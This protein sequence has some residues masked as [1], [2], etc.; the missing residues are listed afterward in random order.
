M[1]RQFSF[2]AF[3]RVVSCS[4]LALACTRADEDK[5]N[6]PIIPD[7]SETAR[8][9]VPED[10]K[11]RISDIFPDQ[12]AW[13]E[14]K[15][16]VVKLINSI[17]DLSQHW[18][19]SPQTMA[20][21]LDLLASINVRSNRLYIY[22]RLQNDMDLSNPAFTSMQGEIRNM[23]VEL[24]SKSTFVGPDVLKLGNENIEAYLSKEPRLAKHRF[25]LT[26]ILRRKDHILPEAQAG[27]VAN[28]GLFTDTAAKTAGLFRDA[29]MPRAEVA[30][31]DGSK[32]LLNESNFLK[33][34]LS[35]KSEDRRTVVEGYFN[36][37]RKFQSTYAS[38]LDGEM[39]KQV[40]MARIHRF[41]GTLA[42]SLFEDDIRPEVYHNLIR[43]VR[44]NLAPLH[45]LLRLKQ[46]MLGLP[47]LHYY[48]V[49]VPAAP[50]VEK[51][52]SFNNARD[53]VLAA[54]TPL[55]DEYSGALRGAFDNR[56][57]DIY[58]NK[59]KQGGAYSM[60]IYG[61]HP[62][63][64]MNYL[65]RYTDVSTLAH[66]LGH[67]MH[68]H[69]SN[70]SQPSTTAGYSIFIAEIA[71]TFNE[72][73]LL[74]QMLKADN[75]DRFKLGLLESYLERMRGTIYAQTMLAEFELAIH[76][77]AEQGQTL[78]A[79]W[80]NAK[81]LE[82]YRQ[83]TGA[84]Q[85]VLKVDD[86]A[87]VTW[88][89]IPHLFRPYYVFQYVTGMVASTALAESVIRGGKPAADRYL[90]VLRAGGG[91]FPLDILRDAGL[92]MSQ[93]EPIVAATQQFDRLV[94]EMEQI[95]S[96]LPEDK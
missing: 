13:R 90:T 6:K 38:L 7:Y 64:K 95:Y 48:D 20:D 68:T 50:T 42:G 87:G 91:K 72:N 51:L 70:L 44:A 59:N 8:D 94:A 84:D 62:F 96:R 35:K 92:D 36:N 77:R 57:I 34:R 65:G 15:A 55:G 41:P 27:I 12:A 29:E 49:A 9:R 88:A 76:E 85:G 81:Y 60:G 17:P 26:N 80:M 69:F 46:K 86:T 33:Y 3:F 78:T 93:P 21:L 2:P 83:Y 32:V 45:R 71:S 25:D 4:V 82:L 43:T 30:L 16:H 19:D 47:E 18:T 54:V 53:I 73:M 23:E 89:V 39:K 66:E 56:W 24:V 22:A 61:I 31:T 67:S 63:I 5:A 75:D 14:E 79:E 40:A 28:V 1:R 11:F 10:F 58:P 37:V 74:N 52:Y